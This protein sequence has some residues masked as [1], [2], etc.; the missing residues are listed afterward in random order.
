VAKLLYLGKRARPDIATAVAFLTTRVTKP[1]EADYMKLR[2]CIGY[3]RATRDLPMTLSASDLGKIYWYVDASFAVHHDMRSHT[4]VVMTMGKGAVISMSVRQKINTKSSTEAELVGVDDAMSQ[5]VW[6]RN[7]M[8]AQGIKVTENVVYQDNQ[9]AI[10]LERNG[11]ASSGKRTRHININ[12]FFVKNHI[13]NGKL[14]VECCPTNE[15]LADILT[16]PLGGSQ[17]R[18]F[19]P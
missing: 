6:T 5:I 13:N 2:R 14:I 1:T 17:F 4:G 8:E 12:Y 7:F 16:K 9:S 15:M 19:D 18:R 11:R 10:L 3:L